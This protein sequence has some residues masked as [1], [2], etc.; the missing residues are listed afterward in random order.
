MNKVLRG[1]A[2]FV[3]IFGALW[4]LIPFI[5]MLLTSFKT[6]GQIYELPMKLIPDPFTLEGYIRTFQIWNVPRYFLN[7]VIIS[8]SVT[9]G[10]VFIC[11]LAGYAF[12]KMR[13]AGRNLWFYYIL[14]SLMLPFQV[15]IIPTFLLLKKFGW[16]NSYAGLI[17]PLLATG[18]AI[19]LIRQMAVAIPGSLIDAARIDGC[20]E[21]RIFWNVAV[22]NLKPGMYALGIITYLSVWN[23][24]LMPLVVV[25]KEEMKPLPLLINSLTTG[26]SESGSMPWPISMA[27]VTVVLIPV[28][29][30]YLFA[31]KY[32]ITAMSLQSGIK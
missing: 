18:F 15:R 20:S 30:L 14:I 19:F 11:T 31:Q 27:A 21:I 4:I 23:D 22:P 8:V 32:I 6:P 17:V 9:V 2:Y 26:Q 25:S 7:S 10:S 16:L 5:W 24:F 12:A 28:L 1:A 29:I 13:F 3:L